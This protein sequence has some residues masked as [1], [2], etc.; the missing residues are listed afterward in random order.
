MTSLQDSF[1]SISQL[2]DS[3]ALPEKGNPDTEQD[4]EAT[5]RL[6]LQRIRLMVLAEYDGEEIR[7][8]WSGLDKGVVADAELSREIREVQELV[9]GLPPSIT[10]TTD[11]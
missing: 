4:K 11:T 8:V 3:V 9:N 1:S 7:E 10:I 6:G 2:A 5:L